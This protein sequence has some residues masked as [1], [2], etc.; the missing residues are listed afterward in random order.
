MFTHTHTQE[1]NV[2]IKVTRKTIPQFF[3][4]K[5]YIFLNTFALFK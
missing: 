2:K 1:A 3:R 4:K 5:K